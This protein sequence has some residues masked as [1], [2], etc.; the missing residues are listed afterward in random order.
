MNEVR[1]ISSNLARKIFSTTTR[2]ALAIATAIYLFGCGE[3]QQPVMDQTQSATFTKCIADNGRSNNFAEAAFGLVG[4]LAGYVH[5]RK[6][7]ANCQDLALH[8]HG[9]QDSSALT[10][11]P[12]N[13]RPAEAPSEPVPAAS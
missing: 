12:A 2:R 3:A 9:S 5:D 13:P 11:P 6:V 10:N 8:T 1:T 7:V 4:G